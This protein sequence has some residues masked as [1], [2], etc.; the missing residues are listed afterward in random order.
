[1]RTLRRDD[2]DDGTAWTL[3]HD[4]SKMVVA[5]VI[6]KVSF[7]VQSFMFV[8]DTCVAEESIPEIVMT[9]NESWLMVPT[10]IG[11]DRN[12]SF[13]GTMMSTTVLGDG[14]EFGIWSFMFVRQTKKKKAVDRY[15]KS[16]KNSSVGANIQTR[17]LRCAS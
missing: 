5:A 2:D 12:T 4:D 3:L 16:F 11:R 13:N 14:S 17:L 10:G 7:M 8:V 6:A 15:F 1:M 9:W